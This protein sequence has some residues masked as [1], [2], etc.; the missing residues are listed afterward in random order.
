MCFAVYFILIMF[1]SSCV[2][3]YYIL[4]LTDTIKLPFIMD[5]NLHLS[6]I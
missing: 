2:L 1:T 5:V 4:H 6:V 3:L